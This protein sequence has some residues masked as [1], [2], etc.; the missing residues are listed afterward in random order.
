M[1]CLLADSLLEAIPASAI[2]VQNNRCCKLMN[3]S[4]WPFLAS[5]PAVQSRQIQRA[6]FAQQGPVPG[7]RVGRRADGPF[8]SSQHR[9][10]CGVSGSSLTAAMLPHWMPWEGRCGHADLPEAEPANLL[11]SRLPELTEAA[12]QTGSAGTSQQVFSPHAFEARQ[13]RAG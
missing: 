13:G 6:S 2:H 10:G 9:T 8:P 12:R 4:K 5:Y 7:C 11:G 1:H 3:A